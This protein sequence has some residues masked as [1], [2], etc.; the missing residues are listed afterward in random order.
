MTSFS[1]P[2]KMY[3]LI[4]GVLD[5]GL[6]Y[7]ASYLENT[8]GKSITISNDDARIEYPYVADSS[9]W[10][11]ERFTDIPIEIQEK[12]YSLN[13]EK[14]ILYYRIP[15]NNKNAYVIIK[16]CKAQDAFAC[17]LALREAKLAI[18]CFFT[19][20]NINQEKFEEALSQYIF[21]Q[22]M[23][24]IHDVLKLSEEEINPKGYYYTVLLNSE[25]PVDESYWKAIKAYSEEFMKSQG[26]EIIAVLNG[27]S[28]LMLIP[29]NNHLT[30]SRNS[31]DNIINYKKAIEKRFQLNT[32]IGIGQSY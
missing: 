3:M 32:T 2:R 24:N 5:K 27:D 16:E 6:P 25:S 29:A 20:L 26:N 21:G 7:V 4:E 31:H 13:E 19:K 1:T 10:L 11:E 18:K 30:D 8:L 17:L 23:A 12:E 14:N 9:L 28:L 15:Y 22:N